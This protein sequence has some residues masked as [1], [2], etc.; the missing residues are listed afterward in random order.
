MGRLTFTVEIVKA[1][2]RETDDDCP[3]KPHPNFVASA[4]SEEEQARAGSSS[5]FSGVC[6]PASRNLELVTR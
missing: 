5:S 4:D 1:P 6:R 3:G 2:V